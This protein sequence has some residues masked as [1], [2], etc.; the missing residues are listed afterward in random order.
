MNTIFKVSPLVSS[1]TGEPVKNQYCVHSPAFLDCY[2]Q[3]YDSL[4]A[5]YD[6]SN[7]ILTLGWNWNYSVTTLKYLRQ[8]MKEYAT[9]IYNILPLGNSFKDSINKAIAAG[10]IVFDPDLQ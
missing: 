3:S 10:L 5:Y 7:K 9:E 1:R 2:F 6:A 8:F 4:I